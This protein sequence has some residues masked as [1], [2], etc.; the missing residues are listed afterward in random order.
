MVSEEAT[1]DEILAQYVDAMGQ[2]LGELVA[3]LYHRVA[4]L[5]MRW[6][7]YRQLFAKSDRR[8]ELLNARPR[9]SSA[10]YSRAL[11]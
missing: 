8:I 6:A 10:S 1:R 7:L 9:C 5:H 2:D 3:A 11:Q 4:W